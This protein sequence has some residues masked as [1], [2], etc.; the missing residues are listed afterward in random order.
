MLELAQRERIAA[1]ER[2]V[3]PAKLQPLDA[4][5]LDRDESFGFSDRAHSSLRRAQGLMI[6]GLVTLFAGI[7]VSLFL[8]LMMH[9]HSGEDRSAWAVGLVPG[10]IGIALLISAGIVWPRG[11]RPPQ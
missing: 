8:R 1:I 3:D 10:F 7:G 5:L 4:S 2:G 6:G 9:D 11:N